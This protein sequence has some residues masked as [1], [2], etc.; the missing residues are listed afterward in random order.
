MDWWDDLWL[1]EGFASYMEY[2][3][4]NASEPHWDVLQY[5]PTD[6]LHG[7]LKLDALQTSHPL[8]QNVSTPDEIWSLF[9]AIT[10]NKGASVLRMLEYTISPD[11][12]IAGVNSYLEKY[13]YSN[14]KTEYLWEQIQEQLSGVRIVYIKLLHSH[15]NNMRNEA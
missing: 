13:K 4:A 15:Y 5:F 9:D 7:V 1:N 11:K 6:D 2:K 3:G 10:Y 12:F 8:I 14:A